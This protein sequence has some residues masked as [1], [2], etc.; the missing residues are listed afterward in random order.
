MRSLLEKFQPKVTAIE[1]NKDINMMKLEELVGS[2]QTYEM[3]LT[4]NKGK[5]IAF[6]TIQ[7]EENKSQ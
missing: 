5:N 3:Q 2:P 4:Q 6:K 1:E 7:K